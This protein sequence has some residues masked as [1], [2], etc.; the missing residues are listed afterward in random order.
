MKTKKCAIILLAIGLG[1]YARPAQAA[2]V[3]QGISI[4]QAPF[5]VYE[6][7]NTQLIA[8]AVFR[9]S[10][11][12][13][14]TFSVI[15][16]Q[17][18]WSK[19]SAFVLSVDGGLLKTVNVNKDEAITVNIAY[20]GKFANKVIMILNNPPLAL[21]IT[22]PSSVNEGA[23]ANCSAT[24]VMRNSTT[25]AV[26][27]QSVWSVAPAIG[28][29]GA[30]TG[31]YTAGQVAGNT[32][33]T[34]SASYSEGGATVNTTRQITVNNVI[35]PAPVGSHSGR[36]TSYQ[37]ATTCLPCHRAQATAVHASEHYQWKGKFGAINDFCIYPDINLI[38]KLT[39]VNGLEVDG[40]C[41]KC[42]TGLGAKPVATT[43]PTDLQLGNIDCL[44][45]HSPKY[46]RT[47]DPVTKTKFIPDE[48]AMGITILEAAVDIQKTSR[49]TCLNCH[50]KSGG[51]NNFKR[52][53]IEEH[54]RAPTTRAFDV[55]MSPASLSGGDLTCT[56]CHTVTSHKIAGKGS[57]LRIQEGTKPDCTACHTAAPH[58]ATTT[59]TAANATRLNTHAKRVACVTCHI[60]AFAKNA[61]T[62][63]RRDWSAPGVLNLVTGLYDPARTM[64]SNVAPQYKWWNGVNSVFYSFGANVAPQANG[65]VLMAG[66]ANATIA[67]AGAKIH[68][69]KVHAA[70]QPVETL[71]ATTKRLLPLKM[72]QFY[73][74]GDLVNAIP[75]GQDGVGWPRNAYTYQETE[76]W[77]GLFH[78]VAPKE[79][80]I[81]YQNCN[82]CHNTSA[83]KVPLKAL[84]YVKKASMTVSQVCSQCHGAETYSFNTAHTNSNHSSRNCNSC[85]DFSRAP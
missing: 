49:A 18:A 26:T 6:N 4:Y 29:I 61:P 82:A 25:K 80:A 5:S 1:L 44:V 45:C 52:G 12:G 85:H 63:M 64:L 30:S 7:T 16:A 13:A 58:K 57:D 38:G 84:G 11:T 24:V 39:N 50:T 28:S 42:H 20:G 46:K 72:S 77:M 41:L 69:F 47:V 8:Q 22:A 17:A 31:I 79:Q 81:G 36:F 53:D 59:V 55:H 19:N 14:K 51:G 70:K 34:V 23:T 67:T 76:R 74:Q 73:M 21:N 60:P 78:E 56:A 15:T 10:V 33:V 48:T 54:H 83:P 65:K 37:G 2:P 62:D 35:A 40:G 68:P 9:D 3:L 32:L 75:Q 27:A 66:P 43:A 71:P